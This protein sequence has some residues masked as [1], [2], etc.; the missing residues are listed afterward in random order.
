MTENEREALLPPTTT[1]L[2]DVPTPLYVGL[3]IG[4][5][6]FF[7]SFSSMSSQTVNA[8]VTMCSYQD[9]GAIIAGVLCLVCAGLGIQRRRSSP[10]KFPV[11]H[12]IVYA[13]AAVLVVLAVVHVLRG[14]GMIG[15]PC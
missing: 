15:G 7:V 13:F 12:W 4:L 9:Y 10:Y 3:A 5:L 2:R 6:G 11:A 14:L 8:E 1:S